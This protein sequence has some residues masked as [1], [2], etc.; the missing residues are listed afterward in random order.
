MS[1]LLCNLCLL[2]MALNTF[3][4]FFIS[5]NLAIE[6]KYKKH[7]FRVVSLHL[8]EILKKSK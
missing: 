5:L 1:L 7:I 4:L 3:I 2:S 6:I 8:G